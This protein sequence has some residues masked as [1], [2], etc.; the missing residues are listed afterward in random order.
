MWIFIILKRKSS[1]KEIVMNELTDNEYMYL[2]LGCSTNDI[3]NLKTTDETCA[4]LE[5]FEDTALTLSL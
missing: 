3:S 4:N 1:L 5:S 2:F